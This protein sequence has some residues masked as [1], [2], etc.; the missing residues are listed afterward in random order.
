MGGLAAIMLRP[1]QVMAQEAFDPKD[2]AGR[3]YFSDPED[4]GSQYACL[5][6]GELVRVAFELQSFI[7]FGHKRALDTARSGGAISGDLHPGY[8]AI[9]EQYRRGE[10]DAREGQRQFDA[11]KQ[12]FDANLY[13]YT[14]RRNFSCQ[15]PENGPK[16]RPA[17]ITPSGP[18]IEA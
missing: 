3:M 10:I 5:S 9:I 14:N 2:F 1:S 16:P 18:T 8:R 6:G 4:W 7:N 12:R 11:L 15:Q 17:P 13:S